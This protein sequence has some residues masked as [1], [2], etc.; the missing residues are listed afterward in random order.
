M[1]GRMRN[2]RDASSDGGIS[3]TNFREMYDAG[4]ITKEEYEKIRLKMAGK[5]KA[6]LGLSPPPPVPPKSE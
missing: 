1:A 4:E 3:L 6:D 2:R 5:M